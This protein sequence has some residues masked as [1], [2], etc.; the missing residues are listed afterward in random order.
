MRRW[1]AVWSFTGVVL[2]GQA[3]LAQHADVVPAGPVLGDP[4]VLDVED[5]DLLDR[6]T[7]PGGRV[8]QELAG[9]GA[10]GG[11]A[12]RDAVAVAES[13]FDVVGQV[14]ECTAQPAHDR[15]DGLRSSSR[16]T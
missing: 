8:A 7:A 3:E 12:Q 9:V 13:V 14:R 15:S 4:A 6:E 16:V 10:P 1:P 11:A 5:V 2:A